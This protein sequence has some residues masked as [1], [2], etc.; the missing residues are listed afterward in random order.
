MLGLLALAALTLPGGFETPPELGDR[1]LAGLG[2]VNVTRAPFYVDP[3]GRRGAPLALERAID[4]ARDHQ[5][6]AFL[7]GGTYRVS[8][9]LQ[10]LRGPCCSGSSGRRIF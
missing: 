4:F 7:P 3:T 6:I 2:V 5:M 9:T 8:G 1:R 10:A